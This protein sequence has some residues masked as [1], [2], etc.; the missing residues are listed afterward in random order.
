MPSDEFC[1]HLSLEGS[2]VRQHL[3]E[4]AQIADG[5]N[6]LHVRF[7]ALVDFDVASLVHGDACCLK[8]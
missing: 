6:T 7:A 1:D 8:A 4:V 5:V 2:R 3:A